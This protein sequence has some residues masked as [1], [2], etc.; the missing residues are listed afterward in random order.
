M[1]IM[2][3]INGRGT[4]FREEGYT[5]PKPLINILG[6]PMLFW[7]LENL[8]LQPDIN[9]FIVYDSEL[10][11]YNFVD[12]IKFNFKN[13][14]LFFIP[15]KHITR[16][17]AET[18]LCGLNHIDKKF[19]DDSFMLLDCDTIYF[20]DVIEKYSEIGEGNCIFY[21]KDHEDKSIYSYIVLDLENNVQ[22]IAEKKKISDNANVGC[23]CFEKG[24]KLKKYIELLIDSKDGR[25]KGEFYISGVYRLMLRD[26]IKIKGT[27]IEEFSCVGTPLQ[28]K[29]FSSLNLG[30]GT[31]RRICFDLDNTLVSYP[32]VAGDYTT[33]K[34]I[35]RVIKF[36]QFL[37]KAGNEII[38][39][40][41]R[42]M[43]THSG[44]VGKIVADVGKITL[45]TI[46]KFSI[47]C[48]ELYF[49]KPFAHHYVDDLGVV[50]DVSIEKGLGFYNSIVDA[51]N[52]NH[53]SYEDN[54]VI[55]VGEVDGEYYWFNNIPDSLIDFFPHFYSQ[56]SASKLILERIKGIPVS[57]LYVNN[58][59][60][61]QLLMK[62]MDVFSIFH[63]IKEGS[64]EVN[65]YENY[66]K[67]LVD[68][69]RE[70]NFKFEKGNNSLNE[71][72]YNKYALFQEICSYL[73][74]YEKEDR[75]EMGVIHGDPVFT[76]ILLDKNGQLKFIDMR[77]KLGNTL[78]IW[79]DIFYD[80][81]KLYQSLRGY[82][83][84]L[85]DM[86]Y[87]NVYVEEMVKVFEEFVLFKWGESR[88][89]DI[90]VITSSLLLSLIPLHN[91]SK[92]SDFYRLA[93]EVLYNGR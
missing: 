13:L 30:K 21:F 51:R 54:K 48:D 88:L 15:I 31:P 6:K 70:T 65:I 20:E 60:S 58:S 72:S 73:D 8:N 26:G 7:V 71:D 47:P 37:Q 81:A 61:K 35:W 50:P 24:A 59:L 2:I 86:E 33:V 76:N 84:I 56:S 49:G 53:I 16:G 62:I 29:I 66:Y 55:K 27:M 42:R 74:V 43:K 67:K 17:P 78:T 3:P 92:A 85:V 41:A 28:L 91:E 40:S 9:V 32:E 69:C 90:K 22:D 68:R 38:I 18:I 75:G 46:E 23:Y 25:E 5:R 10:D 77:G 57:Y 80:Y 79:G 12:L 19:L 34:P 52:F 82:D 93:E 1:N 83:F 45:D 63:G 44:N 64:Q 11:V 36:A 39:Y 87:K 89:R 14:S 4:R